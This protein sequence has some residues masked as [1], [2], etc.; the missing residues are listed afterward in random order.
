MR[1]ALGFEATK[2]LATTMH[3]MPSRNAKDKSLL[4]VLSL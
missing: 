1:L 4:L 3:S 2:L